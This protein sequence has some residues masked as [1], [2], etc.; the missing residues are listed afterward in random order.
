MQHK[1][2]RPLAIAERA[3]RLVEAIKTE[4]RWLLLTTPPRGFEIDEEHYHADR[5]QFVETWPAIRHRRV[6][7][8]YLSSFHDLVADQASSLAHLI[9]IRRQRALDRKSQ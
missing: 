6:P 5:A 8:A 2:T 9:E 4:T 1:I 7:G 3:A